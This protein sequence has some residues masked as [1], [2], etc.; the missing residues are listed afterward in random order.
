MASILDITK[1]LFGNVGQIFN[2]G[3]SF[4]RPSEILN[5]FGAIGDLVKQNNASAPQFNSNSYNALNKTVPFQQSRFTQQAVKPFAQAAYQNIGPQGIGN[6]VQGVANRHPL[7]AAEGVGRMGLGALSLYGVGKLT[8]ATLGVAGGIGAGIGALNGDAAGG[9]Y[10][11][12]SRAPSIAGIGALSNPAQT[13]LAEKVGLAAHNPLLAR[14]L[15]SQAVGLSSIPEGYLM[16]TAAGD[17][18]TKQDALFDYLTGSITG[19]MQKPLRQQEKE[20]LQRGIKGITNE[21]GGVKLL[22]KQTPSDLADFQPDTRP[23]HQA[24]IE[25]LLNEGDVEGVR[26]LLGQMSDSDPYKKPMLNMI[27]GMTQSTPYTKVREGV[28][29]ALPQQ[30]TK[31]VSGSATGATSTPGLFRNPSFFKSILGDEGGYVKLG[32]DAADKTKRDIRTAIADGGDIKERGFIT[33]VKE[34]ANTPQAVKQLVS[35]DYTVK[36]GA[37]LRKDAL[38]LIQLDPQAAEKV[39]LNPQN[40][41]H[42]QIGNELINYYGNHGQPEKAAEIAKGMASSGTDFGRAVQAF[43]N[44]DK[45]TP[46]GALQYAQSKIAEFN[47]ANPT[48][49]LDINDDQVQGL[50]DQA[51]KIQAM[52]DGRERNIAANKLMETVNNLIPSSIADKAITV[53]KAGLLTSLR[54]TER[55]LVGNT[56][57]QGAEIAKDVPAS[58]ADQILGLKT[59]QRSVTLTTKGLGSGA[60]KGFKS[61]G[62]IISTGYDPEEAIS[63]Y[64]V[65]HVTWGDNTLEQG[66]KKYTDAVFRTLGAEDKPFWNAAYA[67]SLYDQAGAEAI[68]A[69]KQGDGDFIEGLISKPTEKM[70]VTATKDANV[71]TFHDQNMASKAINAFKQQASKN[72]YAKVLTE[73]VA[74]FTGVPSAIAGQ[75]VNYSPIGLGKGLIHGGQVLAGSVPELQRQASQE[76][77]R[78]VIGTGLLGIGAYLASKGLITGQP[79]DAAEQRQWQLENK[80]SNSVFINGQ[81]RAIGSI[82]PENL[83]MLAGAKAQEEQAKGDDASLGTFGANIG[84][85]FANQTFLQGVQQP[86][87]AINDP[88]RYGKSYL[89][90]QLS[91]AVPNIVKDTAK[92]LDPSVRETNSVGDY[93]TN[94]IPLLRNQNVE[95]RDALGN[96]IS[97]EPTGAGAFFDLFNSKTPISNSVVDELS[98]LNSTGNNATPTNPNKAQT[99][100]GIKKTLTPAELNDFEAQVGVRANQELTKLFADPAYQALTDEDKAKKVDSVMTAVRKEVRGVPAKLPTAKKAKATTIKG[101]RIAKPKKITIKS[102]GSVKIANIRTRQSAAPKLKIKGMKSVK[103][104]KAK[105]PKIMKPYKVSGFKNSFG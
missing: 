104:F 93:L 87:A 15:Q 68:N 36:S 21:K 2:N 103:V 6:V 83:L 76:I 24:E 47:R 23:A 19:G 86:L 64:D 3:Q 91:S 31:A 7:Q 71:A 90:N 48:K 16:N 11:G 97:Q 43:S 40:D 18:Y 88:Q 73:V 74:P 4:G 32:E 26:S 10:S 5:Q 29:R 22:P 50:F 75:M 69:G 9:F 12:L 20:Q 49:Q 101:K 8:P 65:R 33:S 66:L 72:E 82:G 62:D 45:T 35:G 39:A 105:K 80:P 55:N 96:V 30:T 54:T 27:N 37:E 51:K 81:W 63:K 92:S 38:K 28:Y 53:W 42:V 79:K 13:A 60:V 77:G 95:K 1:N 89:G 17:G 98:R 61:A 94:S 102:V 46:S 85:D 100:N 14:V 58:L 52:P 99:I 25:K 70:L 59:G 78:G 56:I 44:Y 67:R 41:T 34:S 84:K 57:H